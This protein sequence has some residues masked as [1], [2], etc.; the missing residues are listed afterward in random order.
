MKVP[1]K[2]TQ[3]QIE[4]ATKKLVA[5]HKAEFEQWRAASRSAKEPSH[6]GA[7]KRSSQLHRGGSIQAATK[8]AE[9][10]MK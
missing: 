1:L 9:A 8:P 3:R 10:R 2:L 7:D 5:A 6:G 4:N